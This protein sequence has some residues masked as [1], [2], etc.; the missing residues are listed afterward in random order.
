[1]LISQSNV[2]CFG[3]S[4]GSINI[5][6]S[7]GLPGYSFLWSP[8]NDTTEDISGLSAGAYTVL[9][10]DMAGCTKTRSFSISQ[11][12][13]GIAIAFNTVPPSCGVSTG[14]ACANIVGGVPGYSY[15]WSN[16][17]TTACIN[18]IPAG[19]YT[20]TI[21]DANACT[22]SAA[23]NLSDLSGPQIVSVDSMN[24]SCP[25]VA[26]G[27]ISLV[28]SAANP[29]Y[30][31]VWTNTTQ[32]NDTITGLLPNIYTVTLT[33]N[34]GCITA[35]D[36]IIDGPGPW[37]ITDSIPNLNGNF[38]VSCNGLKNASISLSL[39]GGSAPYTFN[40]SNG[41]STQNLNNIGAGTYTI[42]INDAN[43]CDTSIT[44]NIT[45]PPALFGDP[46]GN[47]N[48]CGVTSTMLTA[49]SPP[50]GANGYWVSSNAA[51]IIDDSLASNTMVSNLQP[52]NNIFWWVVTDG[53]CFDSAEVVIIA[54]DEINAIAGINKIVCENKSSLTATP[55]I[56]GFGYWTLISGSG[57]INDSTMATTLVTDLSLG[58]NEF[59]WTVVNGDCRDSAAVIITLDDP[60]NCID[61][62]EL[63]T[64]ITPNNDAK[65]DYYV[66]KGI[67][68]FPINE[69][70]VYNRW[71]NLVY[72]QKNYDNAWNGVNNSGDNLPD[73]TY[74]VIFRL[75][76]GQ[77]AI[78]G[79][80]D[81][82]RR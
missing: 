39:G 15:L 75:N 79:Y 26:D 32:T 81:I 57:N 76:N 72:N 42:L 2:K 28:I 48:I 19:T 23:V 60:L 44:Y 58:P 70:L 64:G 10:T 38:N 4:D 54:S 20:V 45:Q 11:P 63:P 22:K 82:R 30:S 66:I 51:I 62:L 18:S 53:V 24:T 35:R 65:N 52:G 29:P 43:G 56:Y 33:D 3:G 50:P 77:K 14:S 36:I 41:S 21:T 74:Y 16:S 31:I 9:V 8:G 67:E 47:T 25:G 73:G 12:T 69:L 80:V 59:L 68:A 27:S 34:L 46:M 78:N 37:S 40:W 17:A 61:P 6:A 49:A 55:I 1:M 5:A 7:N 71:G 13:A